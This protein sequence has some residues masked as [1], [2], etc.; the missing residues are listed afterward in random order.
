M[1]VSIYINN[2][3]TNIT[4]KIDPNFQNE[5][6]CDEVFSVGTMKAWLD[7]PYNIPPYTP[8]MIGE[9]Y[10]LCSS[11]STRY[12]TYENL[13]VH[14]ITI[15]E[16]TS[17]LSCYILG[18][19]SFSV[20]GTN[21]TDVEKI[22]IISSL[23][24]Q[25]YNVT[26]DYNVEEFRQYNKEQE[27]T[28][29]LGTTVYDAL[30]AI[31]KTYNC[32]P[33]VNQID[34]IGNEKVPY[35]EIYFLKLGEDNPYPLNEENITN[36]ICT[37]NVDNYCK[38]LEAE[39]SNVIDRTDKVLYEGLTTRSDDLEMT[40]KTAK[41]FLPTRIEEVK[42]FIVGSD[43]KFE[44]DLWIKY[45][46]YTIEQVNNIMKDWKDRGFIK[47]ADTNTK[48]YMGTYSQ[49]RNLFI[50]QD[51]DG[52]YYPFDDIYNNYYYQYDNNR[53]KFYNSYFYYNSEEKG[54]NNFFR[55]RPTLSSTSPH[56][57]EGHE[58]NSY[59]VLENGKVEITER[60]LSKDQ[61]DIL[62]LEDKPKYCYY[63]S[64]TNV[65]DGMMEYYRTDLWSTLLGD[66]ARPFLNYVN[67]ESNYQ[68]QY[69]EDLSVEIN[70]KFTI[71]NDDVRKHTFDVLVTTIT[72][73]FVSHDKSKLPINQD[74]YTPSSRSYNKGSNNIDFDKMIISLQKS[75]DMLGLPELSLEYDLGNDGIIPLPGQKIAYK[76][77]N[78]YIASVITYYRTTRRYYIINL[79]SNYNKI[80]DVIGVETQYNTTPNPLSN[81][82]ERTVFIDTKSNITIPNNVWFRIGFKFRENSGNFNK[83]LF[84]RV[85]VSKHEKVTY[86]FAETLDQY[87]FGRQ[88][89]DIYDKET[90]KY[91]NRFAVYDIGYVDENNEVYSYKID[92]V[93]LPVLSIEDSY[94]LPEYTGAYDTIISLP[95]QKLYKDAREKLN[96]TIKI[97]SD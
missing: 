59:L 51:E 52:I 64:G 45:Q 19:K 3:W 73:P 58:Y 17:I 95:E 42:K 37:Q 25:K 11:Q 26:L 82:I 40:D 91:S 22:K 66:D 75:N 30:L 12:L 46:N 5:A 94:K 20:T 41:L 56:P 13:Y 72:N 32:V 49:W 79:V 31:A 16:A 2:R 61:Y 18:S 1:N 68:S 7:I 57:N 84:V 80:A 89:R 97:T 60:I 39:M 87:S 36:E 4:D 71:Q 34:F 44:V 69:G 83:T 33:K 54:N 48:M 6:R 14:D 74:S 10:Y 70:S 65:I 38:T 62:K 77:E 92:V 15:L 43:I 93:K 90:N 28:F 88:T 78:W 8:L 53:E 63:T 24:K 85:S 55:L 50:S 23:M 76:S 96:F 27:F 21:K 86:L 47:L 81:I 67:E 35:V 29:G 9:D